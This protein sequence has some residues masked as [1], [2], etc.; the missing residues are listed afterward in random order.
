MS[1]GESWGR[2]D[3]K[4]F[5]PTWGNLPVTQE[6]KGEEKRWAEVWKQ[7][8]LDSDRRERDKQRE[9]GGSSVRGNRSAKTTLLDEIEDPH[10]DYAKAGAAG[11]DKEPASPWTK[12]DVIKYENE[13]KGVSHR[14]ST[15]NKDRPALIPDKSCR[16][17][18]R[19]P[20]QTRE[21]AVRTRVSREKSGG[22][23]TWRRPT[24]RRI[25]KT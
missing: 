25:G 15:P 24:N 8:S 7:K 23:G 21:S 9:S 4:T 1:V 2:K 11:Y 6:L 22:K 16:A 12:E 3:E 19:L 17:H 20:E 14:M 13:V 10:G 18:L 5:T